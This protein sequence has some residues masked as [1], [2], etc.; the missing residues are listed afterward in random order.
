MEFYDKYN[1][2][3]LSVCANTS[4]VLTMEFVLPPKATV[5]VIVPKNLPSGR[6]KN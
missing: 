1:F 3:N 6:R 2:I 4:E 5:G